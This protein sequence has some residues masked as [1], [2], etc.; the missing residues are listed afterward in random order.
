M[1][2][3]FRTNNISPI[4]LHP[5]LPPPLAGAADED[6]S[7]VTIDDGFLPAR[8]PALKDGRQF[9]LDATELRTHG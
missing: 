1:I 7:E 8:C 9:N 2:A 4:L 3:K 5:E 6:G